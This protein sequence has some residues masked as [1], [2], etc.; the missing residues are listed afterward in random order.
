MEYLIKPFIDKYNLEGINFPSRKDK[1]E[2]IEK[3]NLTIALDILYA[4]NNKEIL[5][6]F[7]DMKQKDGIILQQNVIYIIKRNNIM[8][9][10][11]L[12]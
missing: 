6:T 11:C 3:I 5:S 10:L 8:V 7:Q 1:M 2:K 9:F 4:R 12:S